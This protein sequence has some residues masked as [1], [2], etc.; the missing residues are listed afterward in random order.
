MDA[1]F[2]SRG[3]I[4]FVAMALSDFLWAKY[5]PYAAMKRKKA[6]AAAAVVP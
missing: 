1:D 2:L 5:I 4:A 6:F 3:P